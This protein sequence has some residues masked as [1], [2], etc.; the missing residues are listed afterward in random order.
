[1]REIFELLV[2]QH[3]AYAQFEVYPVEDW[4]VARKVAAEQ[5]RYEVHYE[6][7][8]IGVRDMLRDAVMRLI[9]T[10]AFRAR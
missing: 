1:V 5:K 8:P 3:P 7:G 9:R 10:A 2:K 4:A 6:A